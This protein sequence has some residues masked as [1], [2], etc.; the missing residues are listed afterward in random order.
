MRIR[1]YAGFWWA[2]VKDAAE[3][4]VDR[5]NGWAWLVGVPGAWLVWWIFGYRLMAPDTLSQ[6]VSYGLMFAGTAWVITF[7][8]R[9]VGS[10][11][12]L[13]EKLKQAIPAP[14]PSD[15]SIT[16]N[17]GSAI[18]MNSEFY[19][20][21]R[22]AYVF[23]VH[24]INVGTLFLQKCQVLIVEKGRT[25]YHPVTGFFDLRRG[26]HEDKVFARADAIPTSSEGRPFVYFLKRSDWTSEEGAG[27]LLH[28]GI[29]EIRVLSD[30]SAP[31]TLEVELKHY[32][33]DGSWEF[34]RVAN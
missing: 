18:E 20:K 21:E 27:W 12:R 13:Y 10:P 23:T 8:V 14:L 2:C 15:I 31:A 17:D 7:S 4:T 33:E 22:P 16:L 32:P 19:G 34:T 6:I 24:L 5:A 26:Q 1:L 9:L 25:N 29:Y 3:G 11:A 28:Q 30:L